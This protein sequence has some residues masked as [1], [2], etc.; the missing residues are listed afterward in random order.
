M[1]KDKLNKLAAYEKAIAEKYG[2]EAVANPKSN[3]NEEKEKLYLE[4]MK[5]FY[6]KQNKNLDSYEKVDL[7]GIK[8]SKKLLNRES[9]KSCSVCGAFPKK[10][11]DDVCLI[12]FNTCNSCYIKFIEGRE[13]RWHEGWRP[14]ENFK[15]PN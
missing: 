15:K 14:D 9:L 1:S 2:E 11:M 6:N 12:K 3:W 13:K 4:E 10:S 5:D 8:V 7:N